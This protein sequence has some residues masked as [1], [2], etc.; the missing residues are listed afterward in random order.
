V[1]KEGMGARK[2]YS[3]STTPRAAGPT[4]SCSYLSGLFL[5]FFFPFGE[6]YAR[7]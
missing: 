6:K 2:K 3:S 4:Q 7:F 1:E 5:S